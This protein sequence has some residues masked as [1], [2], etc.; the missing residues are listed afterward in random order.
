MSEPG[1][2]DGRPRIGYVIVLLGTVGFAVSCFIPFLERPPLLDPVFPERTLYWQ[3]VGAQPSGYLAEQV[4]GFLSLFGG[5]ATITLISVL[6]LRG[7]SQRWTPVALAAAALIWLFTWTG[8][9]LNFS[10]LAPE[11]VEAGY[12]A[13]LASVVVVAVGTIIVIVEA[14]GSAVARPNTGVG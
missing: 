12:W 3:Y 7:G 4:G 8:D 5:V 2:E 14:R 6:G 10:G 1:S 13:V 11:A 9:L